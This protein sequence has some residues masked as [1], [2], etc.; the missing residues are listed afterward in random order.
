MTLVKTR[1]S[2][3]SRTSTASDT[4]GDNVAATANGNGNTRSSVVGNVEK[5]RQLAHE[6]YKMEEKQ[7]KLCRILFNNIYKKLEAE[8]QSQKL[9]ERDELNA[10]FNSIVALE[11]MAQLVHG[12][13]AEEI[14][15]RVEIWQ[16]KPY[17][18]DI[19]VKFYHFY[20]AYKAVIQRHHES[21][22]TLS[23]LIK[24]KPKFGM[25][26]QKLLVI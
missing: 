7:A 16:Q 13:V 10:I 12:Q 3:E 17:F 2:S 26:L 22:Q 19:L 21:V 1:S 5:R 8:N 11:K 6:Y 14:R 24:A 15:A 4:S 18:G 23:E 25:F 20:K 9:C